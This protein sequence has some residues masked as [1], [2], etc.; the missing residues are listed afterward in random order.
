MHKMLSRIPHN[1]IIFTGIY[2]YPVSV[3]LIYKLF[4]MVAKTADAK[5]S[6]W[7]FLLIFLL[8]LIPSLLI[9]TIHTWQYFI[10]GRRYFSIRTTFDKSYAL[11]PRKRAAMYPEVPQ[12]Y[13]AE[14]PEWILLGKTG[15]HYVRIDISK[16]AKNFFLIGPLGSGKTATLLA[17]LIENFSHENPEFQVF[18]GSDIKGELHEKGLMA[19]TPGIEIVDPTDRKSYGWDPYYGLDPRMDPDELEEALK[20]IVTALIVADDP[21]NNYFTENARNMLLGLLAYYFISGK[22]FAESML[23]IVQSSIPGIVMEA[24]LK[25]RDNSIAK[26]YLSKFSA[27]VIK[28][29][30]SIQDIVTTMMQSLSL[31]SKN[32]M[33]WCLRDNP[34]K[35]SPDDFAKGRSVFLSIPQKQLTVYAEFFRLVIS[36]VLYSLQDRPE[37][38]A[39]L[40]LVL[41]ELPSLKKIDLLQTSLATIRSRGVSAIVVAQSY[42]QL[43]SIYGKDDATSIWDLCQEKVILNCDDV[44]TAEM[45]SKSAGNYQESRTSTQTS[46][47]LFPTTTG[48]NTSLEQ[49]KRIEVSELMQLKESG[50]VVLLIEG[51]Y[52]RVKKLEYWKDRI[53]APIAQK[54]KEF[55]RRLHH[56]HENG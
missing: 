40:L 5:I 46:G 55:N 52:L 28:G 31:F 15:T 25:S 22:G 29:G 21:R 42:S 30:E 26:R 2:L 17:S 35:A 6:L 48:Y 53:L 4:A 18:C 34:R 27:Q 12:Q 19:N 20:L 14:S 36:Q 11:T 9:M 38:S 49:R 23:I 3:I 16:G 37:G 32:S 33:L 8:A 47:L 44:D 56:E 1:K 7:G 10:N 43:R 50:D 45:I 54:I 24:I 39:P 13:L 41:D 51:I